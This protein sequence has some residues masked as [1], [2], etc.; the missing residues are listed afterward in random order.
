NARRAGSSRGRRRNSTNTQSCSKEPCAW[1]IGREWSMFAKARRSS[2][3]PA[4]GCSTALRSMKERNTSRFAY[5]PIPSMAPIGTNDEW[6]R[7]LRPQQPQ[8]ANRQA[9]KQKTERQESKWHHRCTRDCAEPNA[10]GP[11]AA[12]LA[13]LFPAA[14]LHFKSVGFDGASSGASVVFFHIS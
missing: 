3:M 13:L 12:W 8:A 2:R 4:N 14:A 6:L 11:W 5:R 9:H 1:P 10:F 7:L